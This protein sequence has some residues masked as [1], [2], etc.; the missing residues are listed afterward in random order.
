MNAQTLLFL[1][2][3]QNIYLTEVYRS[4]KVMGYPSI[5]SLDLDIN[6]IEHCWECAYKT[7]I[8]EIGKFRRETT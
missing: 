7:A 8:S 1:K 6:C 4:A 3:D 5:L 2:K